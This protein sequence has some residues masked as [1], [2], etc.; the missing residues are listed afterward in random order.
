MKKISFRL[1][2]EPASF[3]NDP[4]LTAL[5][6]LRD[7]LG[8]LSAKDGCAPQG[9]CGCCTVLWNGR[10]TLSCLRPAASL[11]G[12]EVTTLEGLPERERDVLSRSFV[13]VAGLQCG[14]CIP[15]IAMRAKALLDRHSN[16]DE[17]KIRKSLN[18][19]LCRCTG[20]VKIVD[21]MHEAARHWQ[22]DS[23]PAPHSGPA[24]IG[25]S[26]D[27]YDGESCVLGERPYVDD[28]RVEGM[29][30][31]AVRLA[32]HPRARVLSID[33]GP[34]LAM[35]GVQAVLGAADVPGERR[36]GLIEKDWPV[37][38]AA[39]E[40][41]H[42]LA[43]TLAVVAADTR[44]IARRAAAA[45]VV[46]YEVLEPVTGPRE[47]MQEDAAQVHPGRANHL[48]TCEVKRGDVDA[49]LAASAHVLTE[50]FSSQRIEHAYLEPESCLALPRPDGGVQVHT[51]GQGVHDDQRQIAAVLGVG[52]DQV[53]VQL[54][55]NGG[56][57]GGKED[58][59]I[60]AHT[61]LLAMTLS[62]PV[63]LTVSREQS[64]LMSP[65]RHPI[66]MEY[67]VGCDD[68]GH[69]TAVR[70]RIF[71]DTGGYLSVGDKVLERAAGHSCGPY[72]VPAVDVEAYT[73]YTNN[74]VSGAFRGFGVNQVA[75]AMGGML[76]RLAD[77]VGI[78][79]YDIRD[80][81]LLEV[82]QPFA[83][84]QLMD[85]GLGVRQCLEAVRD[86]YKSARYAGIAC[87]IKNTGIGNGMPDIG[88][89]RIQVDSHQQVTV[90]TGYTEMG[91]GLYTVLRQ[92][93]AHETGISP[94]SIQVQVS[95]EYA[96]ECGMTT[97]SRATM[98]GSEATRRACAALCE[99]LNGGASLADLVGRGFHGE[100]I[101]DFTSKPGDGGDNP[102]THVTF[103]Y[104]AQ[105]VV[106]DD[107]GE[108]SRV[109]ACHD[110]GRIM[111]RALCEG[112]IEGALHMGL[113]YALCEDMPT[114]GGV[115]VSTKIGHLHI[116]K[117]KH[118]PEIEVRLIE[119]PDVHTEYGVK[120][121]GEIGLVPTA[122]A[123]A[124]ALHSFDGIR[125]HTLPMRGSAAG[126]AVLPKAAREEDHA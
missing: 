9:Q 122:P 121:V 39:G 8:V 37:F 56:A 109:V 46:E 96:V 116:L 26:L 57:F 25:Q 97:A 32:D 53:Y 11:E 70:A 49:A 41:V 47:G 69:L 86:V 95:T 76:D 108:L 90:H 27:R 75:F 88:R 110:V 1:N 5:A 98:L 18:A 23:L 92:I 119:V 107:E 54:E 126:R 102:V 31:G 71:G 17:Q 120:G 55:A 44:E 67:T 40:L 78:D 30:E 114:E 104:A 19:H 12:I 35:D 29:L 61:A 100:F 16:P 87:G 65:K 79:G 125:R 106:L 4:D 77:A 38:V 101:C 22:G 123:V 84:G 52:L 59:C 80:R 113:G 89:V 51:Q 2:G 34:A 3:E 14:Y 99:E 82:G 81:N 21:A 58:L 10:P 85:E 50:T 7:R 112:Q 6:A 15:G 103:G 72:F 42:C 60:Q 28:L 20:Y 45:V 94:D 115:P 62:R 117:A 48:R 118:T 73:V 74:P 36:V 33:F 64:M 43:S 111:N 93:V 13:E 63:K 66:E 68:K 105:V 83:T 24:L 91:Q 124:G